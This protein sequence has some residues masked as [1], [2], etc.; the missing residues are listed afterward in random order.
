MK[1]SID[2]SLLLLL[3]FI[4]TSCSHFIEKSYTEPICINKLKSLLIFNGWE[5]SK[6]NLNVVI[7]KKGKKLVATNDYESEDLEVQIHIDQAK[8]PQVIE[9]GNY[10]IYFELKMMSP[11]FKR[12]SSYIDDFIKKT[13]CPMMKSI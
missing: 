11:R 10:G 8:T 5:I 2:K 3:V 4:T 13:K 7:L 6:E 1:S 12:I 9:V